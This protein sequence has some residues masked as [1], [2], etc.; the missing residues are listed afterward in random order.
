[1]K[2]AIALLLLIL[3]AV[4]AVHAATTPVLL[5][6]DPPSALV[7][8][9][10]FTMTINGANFAT[11]AQARYNG[12]T[13]QTQL[14]SSSKVTVV[15]L[16][17]DL[18]TAGTVPITVTNPGA[19]A[20]SALQFR[21]L[22]N[23][24]QITSLDPS[25][26]AVGSG[27][28]IVGVRGQ[29]FGSQS[30]VRVNGSSRDTVFIDDTQLNATLTENDFR[31]ATSLNITVLNPNNRI[32]NTQPLAVS[33][34]GGTPSITLLDPATVRSGGPGFFLNIVGTNFVSTSTIRANGAVRSPTFIDAQHLR[35]QIL[36]IDIAQPGNVSITVT[37]PNGQVSNAATLAVT[38]ANLP[39]IQ[40][41]S[42]QTVTAGAAAFTL[43]VTGQNFA[44]GA[45]AKVGT[46]TRNATVLDAQRVN[47][48]ILTSD[49]LTPGSV[50]ISITTPGST[51]GTSNVINLFVVSQNA[52]TISS[53]SPSSVAVGAQPFKLLV[54]GTKFLLD[55][56]VLINGAPRLT[57]F[58]SSTQ[59]VATMEEVDLSTAGTLN[60]TVTRKD[61]SGTSSPV[62][63]TVTNAAAPAITALNPTS[64]NVGGSSQTLVVVGRN[65]VANS[66]VTVDN[67]PRDTEFIST[68]EL[69][70]TLRTEDLASPRQLSIAVAN[71]GGSTSPAVLLPVVIPVP[72]IATLSPSSVIA[73]DVEFTLTVTGTNFTNRSVINVSG[74]PKATT[75]QTSTGALQASVTAAEITA[76]GTLNITVTDGTSVSA[77][78]GLEVRRPAIATVTPNVLPFGATSATITV[79]GTAFLTTSTIFF[80]GN[81]LPTVFNADGSLTGTLSATDL[82]TPGEFFVV[83]RNSAATTSPGVLVTVASAGGPVITSIDPSSLLT[84][85][86]DRTISIRGQNFVQSSTARV[87]GALR[88]PTFVS[89]NELRLTLTEGD[90]AT[91]RVLHIRV[92][93]PDETQSNEVTLLV[94]SST[95][96][97]RRRPAGR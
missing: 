35:A 73:G 17:V 80:R 41:I 48:P 4:P 91:P 63:L 28:T 64:V 49:I 50:P 44:A 77:P 22:P 74:V 89:A 11:G 6:L 10:G 94:A 52:P 78:V 16:N 57:E 79:T 72:T 34:S 93:N 14:V 87:E 53:I 18:N 1:M 29:N 55:D 60:V 39:V 45:T 62:Q 51:G 33:A 47:V 97:G 67:D 58:V 27:Q 88:T 61:G 7:G 70:A 82:G 2:S 69:H 68:G 3:V 12:A 54:T 30:I 95:P 20:S 21:V 13:R 9:G 76:P 19:P 37:N 26:V 24:P 65:F 96:P 66:I 85:A 5:S 59:L 84:G 42:P 86:A 43:S 25:T 8:T 83:V 38:N 40:S 32:S 23:S 75:F 90:V 36:S 71:P 56:V 15:I 31:F 46:A 81:P 92:V